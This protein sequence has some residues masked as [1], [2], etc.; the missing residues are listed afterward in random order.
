M[1]TGAGT[2]HTVILVLKNDAKVKCYGYYSTK[3]GTKWY[4]VAIDKYAGFVSSKYI[5]RV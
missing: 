5:K 1:R 2:D 4:L 3:G